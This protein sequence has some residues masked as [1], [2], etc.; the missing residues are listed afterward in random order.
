MLVEVTEICGVITKKTTAKIMLQHRFIYDKMIRRF[1]EYKARLYVKAQ[2]NAIKEYTRLC[3][4]IDCDYETRDNYIYSLTDRKKIKKEVATL[5]RIG[6][7]AEFSDA[8]ELH[9]KV[10]GGVRV[11]GQAQFHPLKFLYAIA[12]ECRSMRIPRS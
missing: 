2:S 11:K 3:E 4:R 10:A 12:K 6:V 5:N 8:H 7:K 1:G 9:L